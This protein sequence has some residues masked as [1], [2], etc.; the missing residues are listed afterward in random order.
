MISVLNI[1]KLSDWLKLETQPC[2]REFIHEN[3]FNMFFRVLRNGGDFV[4]GGEGGDLSL[5]RG[6]HALV[7]DSLAQ[8][9][10]MS[11]VDERGTV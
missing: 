6:P 10:C 8:D 1:L 5:F 9:Y 11:C 3:D 4:R 7:R 2:P